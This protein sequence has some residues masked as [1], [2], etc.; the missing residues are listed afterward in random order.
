MPVE[1]YNPKE[2][3]K[4]CQTIRLYQTIPMPPTGELT[5]DVEGEAVNFGP[6]IALR[7]KAGQDVHMT[8]AGAGVAAAGADMDL[9]F[10]GA[11]VIAVGNDLQV[12]NGGAVQITTGRDVTLN[13][14]GALQ[15]TAGAEAHLANSTTLVVTGSHV[16]ARDSLVGVVLSPQVE[17]GEGARVLFSTRQAIALGAAFGAVFGLLSW[18]LKRR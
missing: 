12:V 15:I 17:L 1:W 6:G 11:L 9:S 16:T 10:G 14:A 13:N 5:P 4:P 8:Q 3:R 7:V 2:G 18:L